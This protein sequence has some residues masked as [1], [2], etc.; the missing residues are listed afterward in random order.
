MILKHSNEDFDFGPLINKTERFLFANKPVNDFVIQEIVSRFDEVYVVMGALFIV[1]LQ[2]NLQDFMSD[3]NLFLDY[4][5]INLDRK[6]IG[7][8]INCIE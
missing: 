2:H 1:C 5:G 4:S 8:I 7:Y 3:L 6:K